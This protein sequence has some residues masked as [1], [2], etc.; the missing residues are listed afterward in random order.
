M[1]Y[2]I[3]NHIIKPI[4]LK[5]TEAEINLKKTKIYLML[6]LKTPLL[7][8]LVDPKALKSKHCLNNN[9]K[10]RALRGNFPAFNHFS[11]QFA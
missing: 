10:E 8:Q 5:S 4:N 7:K 2:I 9:Q 1:P 6:F 3:F 11:E